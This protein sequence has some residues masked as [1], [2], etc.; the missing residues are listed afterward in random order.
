M[1]SF[2]HPAVRRPEHVQLSTADIVDT[3]PGDSPESA[4]KMLQ[5]LVGKIPTLATQAPP[6]YVIGDGNKAIA[7]VETPPGRV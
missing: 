7:P 4:L 2:L 5:Y 3:L 1:L 6:S